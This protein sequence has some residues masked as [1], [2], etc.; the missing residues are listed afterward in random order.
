VGAES[1]SSF[2]KGMRLL[3][4]GALLD[5]ASGVLAIVALISLFPA[6]V[7]MLGALSALRPGQLITYVAAFLAVP[8]LLLLISVLLSLVATY[9]FL[10]PSSSNL[11][12]WS[13]KLETAS[14]LMKVGYWGALAVGL[15]A[16]ALLVVGVLNLM[17]PR[18]GGAALTAVASILGFLGAAIVTLILAFL[19]WLGLILFLFNLSSA[20]GLEGFKNAAALMIASLVAALLPL[21]VPAI[22]IVVVFLAAA[23][24]LAAWYLVMDA[25]GRA[26]R[27]APAPPPPQTPAASG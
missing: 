23:L 19:G 15:L 27:Q 18:L 17:S 10:I 20:T 1:E 14:K 26:L 9:A 5:L 3:R 12:R 7:A 13:S 11:A 4:T 16:V 2:V 6:L 21:P 24:S 8:G 25:A 22:S